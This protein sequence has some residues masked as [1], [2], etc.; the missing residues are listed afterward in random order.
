MMATAGKEIVYTHVSLRNGAKGFISAENE[1]EV[2][3]TNEKGEAQA[4]DRDTLHLVWAPKDWSA[5]S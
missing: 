3:I 5:R 2:T 4:Y 1:D